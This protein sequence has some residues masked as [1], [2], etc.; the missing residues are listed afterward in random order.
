MQKNLRVA[1]CGISGMIGTA[2]EQA[3]LA[4]GHA[5]TGIRRSDLNAGKAHLQEKLKGCDALINLAGAS[6]LTCWTASAKE[7]IYNSRIATT[8][9]LV[10]A[11]NGMEAPPADFISASA[12][13]IY[14]QINVHDEFSLN[15]SND[16]LARVCRDWEKEALRV[17]AQ[18]VRLSI[19]RLGLVLSTRGGA[20][21]QMLLPFKLGLGGRIASGRQYFPWVHL[22]DVV[23]AIVG[24]VCIPR[25]SGVYNLVAPEILTNRTFTRK[26]AEVLKRPAFLM[27]PEWALKLIFGEGASVLSTGQQVIPQR[28]LA[29]GFAFRFPGLDQAL[30]FELQK[31][32]EK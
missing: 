24:G 31:R 8:R 28:L 25:A 10:E 21:K 4:Q 26:M 22:N 6:I 30:E 7:R 12:V 29:D 3:L 11:I 19:F 9:S 20:L 2:V 18:R 16:F 17:D 27:V 23:E 13:G 5:V 32:K 14:D 15:Y 1:I